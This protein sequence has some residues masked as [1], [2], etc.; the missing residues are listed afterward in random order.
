M[1]KYTAILAFLLMLMLSL[2]TISSAS[3]FREVGQVISS[4]ELRLTADYDAKVVATLPKNT[5]VTQFKIVDGGWSYVQANQY[6]GYVLTRYLTTPS[7]NIKIASSKSGLVV[8]ETATRSAKTVATLKH[9]MIVEDFGAVGGGWSF[10]QYG[11]VTGYV[12]SAF[13]GTAK[14]TA[15]YVAGSGDSIV[16]NIASPSGASKGLIKGG[17][18]V[19]VHSQIAGWSYITAGN[20]RGYIPSAQLTSKKPVVTAPKPQQLTTFTHLRPSKLSWME[21]YIDIVADYQYYV[22]NGYVE[23]HSYDNKYSYTVMDYYTD[24]YSAG[25]GFN[26]M[27]SGFFMGMPETDWTWYSIDGPLTQNVAAPLY[28]YDYGTEEQRKIGNSFLRTT[29]GTL[30]T[31]AGTFKNVVHIEQKL[32]NSQKSSHFYF[33][34]GYG[35]IKLHDSNG[36]VLFELRDYY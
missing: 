1:K 27:P 13:I 36:K 7:S 18:A 6:K 2:P 20:L 17:T 12:N 28:E 32:Y 33:A 21:F 31:P 9:N 19:A 26:F 25:A 35:L 14:T 10:V 29:T 15:R 11:N 23:D 16:R 22:Y 24:D 8:K 5:L 4:M 3:T 34:P 30:T